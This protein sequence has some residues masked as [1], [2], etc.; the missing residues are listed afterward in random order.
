[1]KND[2]IDDHGDDSNY[3]YKHKTKK[4]K[5][6][7]DGLT[8][9]ACSGSVEEATKSLR[10]TVPSSYLKLMGDSGNDDCIKIER[11]KDGVHVALFPSAQL[12]FVYSILLL[13][14]SAPP[15]TVTVPN[16]IGDAGDVSSNKV[17]VL[18]RIESAL[19][20]EIIDT[21]E[22]IGFGAEFI[23]AHAVGGE[24]DSY[25]EGGHH[26]S[27]TNPIRNIYLENIEQSNM[28]HVIEILN[29]IEHVHM[30]KNVDSK[31]KTHH[32]QKVCLP[33]KKILSTCC[34]GNN[35]Y[36]G[37]P[38]PGPTTETTTIEISYDC[39]QIG[40][41][42]ILSLIEPPQTTKTSNENTN[43]TIQVTDTSSYQNMIA[44][45]EFR[46]KAEIQEY[47]RSFFFSACCAIPVFVISM[48]LVHIPGIIKHFLHSYIFWNITWE[49]FLTWVLTTP[50]QF[51]S[52][53]RFYRDAYYSIKGRHLNMGFLIAAGTSAAYFYSVFVVL[54]NAIR[55]AKGH[56]RLMQA[57]ET[58]A[59]LI[60]FV[61]LGKYLEC[62]VKSFT[63]GA[64]S[65]L[66]QLTPEVA[67]L[68]GTA[69]SNHKY[70]TK[71]TATQGEEKDDELPYD[72]IPE[73]QIPLILLQ[74]NDVLVIRPGEKVPT[75]GIVILGSTSIDE[76]MLTG[77]SM[78]VHKEKGDSVIGGTINIDGSIYIQVHAIGKDTALSKIIEL[79]E[80]AQSSKAPIQEYAD[81]I[82]S[83][84]V[85]VV[86]AISVLTYI[87]WAVLL[88]TGL[89]DGVKDNWPYRQEGLNDWTLP[90]LF[91]ISCLVIACPCALGLATPTAVMVGSGVSAKYG[92]LIKGGEAL[93]SAN[94][95]SAVV[96]DK[97]GTL[98]HGTPVVQD[99][100]LL[101]DRSL[102]RNTGEEKLPESGE[103]IAQ[104]NEK[105][106]R[107]ILRFAAC[108][109]YGS[110][111]PLAKGNYY[112]VHHY[113]IFVKC[114]QLCR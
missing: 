33:A 42:T 71:P 69:K 28:N 41:R 87:L 19:V 96:F 99:V 106:L 95:I 91:S 30:V 11:E 77:E 108:A 23:S 110:E 6:A 57:F 89:L 63:S 56:D 26:D 100:L 5:F 12:E 1:M 52:G 70:D 75:D 40:I 8:C 27:N 109:E 114:L 81:W 34:R 48:I 38:T 112:I 59:L 72:P 65:K 62:K 39:D 102:F 93:E 15:E 68:V 98:T 105:V 17:Q 2:C 90:L 49:E 86:T 18:E 92:I 44:K 84:F 53:A 79:I 13:H 67:N 22:S 78:P 85:P 24:E 64:I 55:D 73:Q 14:G 45:A 21:I 9:S 103:D 76:S 46:R 97:T 32:R 80:S 61:L 58:S 31:K 36:N 113:Y 88:N 60:M 101:S 50:V 10:F 16:K 35:E 104:L 54:Y 107:T 83:R 94:N 47:F 29:N 37:V 51:Y 82:A 7:L 74:K 3:Y 43:Y 20:D 111:H 66:S 25:N 4:L